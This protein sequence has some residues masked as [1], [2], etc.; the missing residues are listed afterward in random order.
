M[1]DP[2][3][4]FLYSRIV[5]TVRPFVHDR[6]VPGLHFEQRDGDDLAVVFDPALIA[7]LRRSLDQ[8]ESYFPKRGEGA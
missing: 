6:G 1:S 4:D 2:N 8:L 3:R 7:D 5:V